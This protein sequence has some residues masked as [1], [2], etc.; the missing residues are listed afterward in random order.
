MAAA[1]DMVDGMGVERIECADACLLYLGRMRGCAGCGGE[2][3]GAG[4]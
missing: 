3:D 4:C 1:V 2:K